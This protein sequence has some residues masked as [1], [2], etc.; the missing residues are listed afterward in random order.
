MTTAPITAGTV[1][2]SWWDSGGQNLRFISY[3]PKHSRYSNEL[4]QMANAKAANDPT[5]TPQLCL[6]S[7]L[8]GEMRE[9]NLEDS[10]CFAAALAALT[11]W[12]FFTVEE[13]SDRHC[14]IGEVR[15]KDR[16]E[17]ETIVS[18]GLRPALG[19]LGSRTAP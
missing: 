18:A 9:K 10:C 2:V 14:F 15:A 7:S 4:L 5:C 8:L 12:R 19:P 1:F 3:S 13:T 6:C 11:G 17:F 16:A